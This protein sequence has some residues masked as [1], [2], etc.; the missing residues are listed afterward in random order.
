MIISVTVS[1]YVVALLLCCA[2]AGCMLIFIACY[3][4][5]SCC[6]YHQDPLCGVVRGEEKNSV[7]KV[8]V[9]LCGS[10]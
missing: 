7:A 10:M 5:P 1:R 8:D 4:V 6:Q 9:F 2:V 3:G